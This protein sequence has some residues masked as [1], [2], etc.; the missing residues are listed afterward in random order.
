M[1]FFWG[2]FLADLQNH[3]GANKFLSE[4]VRLC[5]FLSVFFIVLG[6]Y[7]ASYPESHPEWVGWSNAQY[8]FLQAILPKDP[9]FARYATGIGLELISLGLHFSPPARDVLAN[10]Y[11]IWLGKQSFAVYLLHGPMIRTILV[12]MV[13]GFTLPAE[14]KNSKGEITRP[15]IPFPGNM[16]LMFALVFWIPMNYGVAVLWGTYVD[17]WCARCTESMVDYITEKK[18]KGSSG[19]LP[20]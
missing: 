2:V 11:F 7:I 10:K 18:E 4:K 13:Y 20:A 12:W 6:L 1:Q 3:P 5:R 8:H 16:R 9:D 14:T 15:N 17:P 19:L